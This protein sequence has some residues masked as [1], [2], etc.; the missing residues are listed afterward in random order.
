MSKVVNTLS[1]FSFSLFFFEEMG[2][3]G[4][5]KMFLKPSLLKRKYRYGKENLGTSTHATQ[6]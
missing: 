4:Q 2:V 1:T 6:R 5:Q 3:F